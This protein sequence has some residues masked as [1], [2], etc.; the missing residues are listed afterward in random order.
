MSIRA[1]GWLKFET[2]TLPSEFS[3][4]TKFLKNQNFINEIIET[5]N[6]RS[7]LHWR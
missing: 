7:K 5:D 6:N 2:V 3:N 4:V 1:L